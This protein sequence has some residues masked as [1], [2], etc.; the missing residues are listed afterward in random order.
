MPLNNFYEYHLE[1]FDAG[2]I[3]A[4]VS[5]NAEHPLFKGHFPGQPV[6]PGVALIEII[7][8][9]LSDTL[10][11]KL[12]LTAAKDIKFIAVIIP[13]N[14][15]NLDLAIDY[16]VVPQGITTNCVFS[17]NGQIFTKLRGDFREE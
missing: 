12:M 16:S 4:R 7:R 13:T 10:N 9:I 14:T 15:T 11:K 8:Q 1:S 6:T 3:K 5:I 2:T 17:G